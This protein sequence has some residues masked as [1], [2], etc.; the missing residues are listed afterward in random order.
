[1]FEEGFNCKV[2]SFS[3]LWWS[4]TNCGLDLG[5]IL[6]LLIV[7]VCQVLILSYFRI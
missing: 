1:M 3:L 7:A 5:E 2:V 6:F 4:E